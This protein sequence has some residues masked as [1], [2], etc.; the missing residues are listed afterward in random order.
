MGAILGLL[1]CLVLSPASGG[2]L[3]T[4]QRVGQRKPVPRSPA[5]P[6]PE[7]PTAIEGGRVAAGVLVDPEGAPIPGWPLRIVPVGHFATPR[8]RKLWVEEQ[9][10]LRSDETLT[11]EQGRF[12]FEGLGADRVSFM[13]E[14]APHEVSL[15]GAFK[16]GEDLRVVYA[17]RRIELTIVDHAGSPIELDT[18]DGRWLSGRLL[19]DKRLRIRREGVEEPSYLFP[20]AHPMRVVGPGRCAWAAF[21][22]EPYKVEFVDTSVPTFQGTIEALAG[23]HR[24]ELRIRLDPP[25]TPGRLKLTLLQPDGAPWNEWAPFQLHLHEAHRKIPIYRTRPLGLAGRYY[26]RSPFEIDLAPGEYSV[27]V[28]AEPNGSC[29]VQAEPRAAAFSP[30]EDR[31]IVR[32]GQTTDAHLRLGGSGRIELLI[33]L[34]NPLPEDLERF[35][36]GSDPRSLPRSP[37]RFRSAA[38]CPASR[39]RP[40]TCST[41]STSSG[42]RC[43]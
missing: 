40:E 6:V 41:W 32:P 13:S 24:A 19:D 29:K 20:F 8:G 2:T 11:D 26:D 35:R 5:A 43:A 30:V 23:R 16:V 42:Y 7:E 27:R 34:P 3:G 33:D 22:G 12:R 4:T 28:T 37:P 18:E 17:L 25:V 15:P 39:R 1:A 31:F 9:A 21:T 14:G 10:G 36:F 38:L